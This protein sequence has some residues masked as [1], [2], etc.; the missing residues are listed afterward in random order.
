MPL[1]RVQAL[2]VTTGI[3]RRRFGWYG[4]KVVSLAQD[5]KAGNHVVVPFARMDEIAPVVAVTGFRLPPAD[6]SWRRPSARHRFDSAMVSAVPLGLAA[7][8]VPTINAMLGRDMVAP[9][10]I[11]GALVA[12]AAFFAVREHF[13]W[14]HDRHALDDRHIY[15]RR[16]W[17]APRL[18]IASRIKLQS[19]EIAQGPL[20]RRRG[21][22]EVKFGVAGGTLEI[23]G[24]PLDD[25]R[26]IR[27]A[28]LDSIATV[29]FSRLPG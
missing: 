17:L 29:D 5:A 16:G 24:I 1:H 8:A 14:R 4:L 7:V 23:A 2:K 6:A 27:R 15:V 9:L 25:A 22:A 11:S 28:V 13:L 10:L 20:A 12:L 3:V 26:A 18:D 21:Y 19:V